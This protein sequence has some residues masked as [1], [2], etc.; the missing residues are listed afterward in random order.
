MF[1]SYDQ[2]VF[3]TPRMSFLGSHGG[4]GSMMV[5]F[6]RY[7]NASLTNNLKK[8]NPAW[9]GKKKEL[10]VNFVRML[11]PIMKV[12]DFQ[13]ICNTKGT[14][15][16]TSTFSNVYTQTDCQLQSDFAAPCNIKDLSNDHSAMWVE[17][18]S[19]QSK[20]DL[21]NKYDS[22]LIIRR[23]HVMSWTMKTPIFSQSHQRFSLSF[24]ALFW[25]YF[26]NTYTQHAF[27]Q[28]Q[29]KAFHLHVVS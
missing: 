16:E 13:F 8:D 21:Q 26:D 29:L 2:D 22:D 27:Y 15:K 19:D 10:D 7:L 3:S 23:N 18:E 11:S 1:W 17:Q 20:C 28:P 25:C 14:Q 5:P 12:Q 6:L 4:D 9:Q 24:G